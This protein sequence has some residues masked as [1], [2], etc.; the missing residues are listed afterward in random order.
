MRGIQLAPTQLSVSPGQ[1]SPITATVLDQL[2]SAFAA[3]PAGVTLT[4]TSA[5]TTVAVVDGIGYVTGRGTGATQVTAALSGDFGTFT[6]AASVTVLPPGS[7]VTIVVTPGSPT[8][9]SGGTRQLT[10]TARDSAGNPLAVP[11]TWSSGTPAVAS[12]DSMGLVTGHLVGGAL[13]TASAGGKTGTDSVTVVPGPAS[14]ATSVVSVATPTVPAGD[15]ITLTLTTQDAAGNLRATGGDTVTFTTSG[16]S[17]TGAVG[18]VTDH[19]NGV[20]TA[21]FRGIS[22]GTAT[23][24]GAIIG[25]GAV[26]TTLPTVQVTPGTDTLVATVAISPRPVS[27]ASGATQQLTIT[28]KDSLGTVLTGKP[29]VW[30]SSVPGVATVNGTGLVTGDT[31]GKTVVTATVQGTAGTDSITVTPGAPSRL[32]SL[33]TAAPES[34]AIGDSSLFVLVTKDA[35]GNP[36]TTGGHSVTFAAAGG[37][38]TGTVR[39]AVDHGNGTY[40]AEFVGTAAGTALTVTANIDAA[41]AVVS[42]S[43]VVVTSGGGAHVL[44]WTNSAG[45]AWTTPTNW[46]PPRVPTPQ[47]TAILDAPGGYVVTNSGSNVGGLVVG[48]TG[49]PGGVIA[50]FNAAAE[51]PG[52]IIIH[53]ADT[54]DVGE[55]VVVG[56]FR[57][58]GVI[59]IEDD[60][61]GARTP[62]L[63]IDTIGPR[64]AVNNGAIDGGTGGVLNVTNATSL[65]NHGTLSPGLGAAEILGQM[66]I[67]GNVTLTTGSV[68]SIDLAGANS[69]QQDALGI[70]GTASLGDTLRIQLRNGYVPTRGTSFGPV[71]WGSSSGTF[72]TIQLPPLSTGLQWQVSYTPVGL[73]LTV[74]GPNLS[75][76]QGDGQSAP[77]GAS[78]TVP[79]AVRLLDAASHPIA[80]ASVTFAVTSGGGSLTDPT[81]VPTDASGVAQV[82]GWQLGS[83]PGTNTMSATVAFPGVSGNPVTFT[84]TGAAAA[85]TWTGAASSDWSVPLNWSPIGAPSPLDAVSIGPAA[86]EPVLTGPAVAS[87]VTI[88]G[89]GALLTVGGQTLTTSALTTVNGGLLVMTNPSDLVT[90]TGPA[91]FAGGNE[92]GS[93]TA[94]ELRVAGSFNQGGGG[95][96]SA[97]AASGTHRTVLNGSSL[98]SV[99][100]VNVPGSAFQDLDISH[101]AG[102]NIQFDVNGVTVRGAL[103]SQ[104][105]GGPYPLLYG[106][107]RSITAG[108][109]SING[110]VVQQSSLIAVEGSTQ[111]PEQ[112]DNVIFQDQGP[113]FFYPTHYQLGLLVTGGLGPA[114]TLTFNNVTFVSLTAGDT[115]HYL[116]VNAPSGSVVVNI[117]GTNVTD[118]PTYTQTTGAVT[119]NW[120]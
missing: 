104:P 61:D 10:A 39:P 75:A 38:S 21:F 30:T 48:A 73:V 41:P 45:G 120:P 78:V 23:T 40:T 103:I 58:D 108:Q 84:A 86:N 32:T 59:Y 46:N 51:I 100:F 115:G 24:V 42:T 11:V 25:G 67:A 88:S 3:I 89:A 36:L 12:V 66:T 19:A 9:A 15:S 106:L 107:G 111:L 101:T 55:A 102:I 56:S 64:T 85:K 49:G 72:G 112:V 28:V 1:S 62:V 117:V 20:Y 13:V 50:Y 31:V 47:D 16:G 26:T 118:G 105:G 97:F 74:I 2:D 17:S 27:L 94:G 22:S 98:Q 6:A 96:P 81:T 34:I 37:T 4:W 71:F 91:A 92:T 7:V 119:V 8:V 116:V 110:L 52:G 60:G 63:A 44:H 70:T 57:N 35:A 87:T 43:L 93:L 82:G 53:A 54:L 65:V 69:T 68:V 77:A 80:G 29:V 114:R 99:S 113:T 5:D 14:P 18:G 76:Y 33:V 83:T 90:V 79:P 95:D 109:L